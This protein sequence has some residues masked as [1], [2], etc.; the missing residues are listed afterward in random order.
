MPLRMRVFLLFSMGVLEAFFYRG[1]RKM[2]IS[3]PVA[4]RSHKLFET[5]CGGGL[6]LLVRARGDTRWTEPILKC[7]SGPFCPRSHRCCASTLPI[8]NARQPSW[9]F[10]CALGGWWLGRCGVA[11]APGA[12][13]QGGQGP[14]VGWRAFYTGIFGNTLAT[15]A[16]IPA[17][18]FSFSLLLSTPDPGPGCTC[19]S[20]APTR[21]SATRHRHPAGHTS[22][23]IPAEI[24]KAMSVGLA[25]IAAGGHERRFVSGP[26]FTGGAWG[27][28]GRSGLAHVAVLARKCHTRGALPAVVEVTI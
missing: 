15:Y 22:T 14:N 8:Q 21:A 9:A 17:V 12:H 3:L 18:I 11:G 1:V 20:W 19:S 6:W 2:Q 4:S 28:G 5:C 10:C 16:P 7:F 27:T 23:K 26:P 24:R 13:L 25:V